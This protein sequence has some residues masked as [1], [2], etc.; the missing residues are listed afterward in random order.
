MSRSKNQRVKEQRKFD[1]KEN[2][3]GSHMGMTHNKSCCPG[4]RRRTGT[5]NGS[6]ESCG[7]PK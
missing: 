5:K 7:H 4:C 2:A 3:N 6:C 1:G